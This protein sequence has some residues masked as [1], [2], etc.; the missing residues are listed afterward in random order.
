MDME[1]SARGNAV[2]E[3]TLSIAATSLTLAAM[4]IVA[5]ALLG[6]T[7]YVAPLA[8]LG[9]VAA[10]SIV[11]SAARGNRWALGGLLALC[12]V[13]P[14]ISFQTPPREAAFETAGETTSAQNVLRLILW[15]A[16]GVVACARWRQFVP[17]LKDDLIWPFAAFGVFALASVLWAPIPA[18]TAAAALGFLAT[19]FFAYLIAADLPAKTVF[20]IFFGSTVL[21]FV[22][23]LGAVAV[24]PD[25]AWLAPWEDG[26]PYRLVGMSTHPNVL[27]KDAASFVCLATALAIMQGRKGLGILA[28]VVGLIIVFET[29]SRTSLMALAVALLAP[30][31]T[32]RS[33]RFAVISL[34]CL[35]ALA[36]FL[37]SLGAAPDLNTILGGAGRDSDDSSELLTLTG[38]TELWGFVWDKIQQSP[39]LG[40]GFDAAEATLSKDWW[41]QAEAQ[42]SAHNVWLQA[43]LILGLPGAALLVFWQIRLLRRWLV[44]GES[45]M[46]FL[47]PYVLVVGLTEPEIVAHPTL[48]TLILFLAIA[49]DAKRLVRVRARPVQ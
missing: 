26:R 41:G 30:F 29:E 24:W 34:T 40:Y 18:Y 9:V 4:W 15:A 39:I 27:A 44:D 2:F 14:N 11:A 43:L 10:A 36:L 37:W 35:L 25:V 8:L 20:R 33:L 7:A 49:L 19:L 45:A 32:R 28:A 13:A 21:Y 38:R 1:T 16:M 42:H 17:L 6:P 23:T 12:L 31:V 5:L 22:I 47:T 46:R 3:W 48:P